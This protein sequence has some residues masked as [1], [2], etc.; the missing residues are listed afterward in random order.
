MKNNLII[1]FASMIALA[2]VFAC[3]SPD[4][5]G[6]PVY[7][8]VFSLVYIFCLSVIT[9]VLEL[10]YSKTPKASRR[11][12]AIVLAFSPTI[13]LAIATLSSLTIID[14]LLA[15]GI[16][17]VIVWYGLKGKFIK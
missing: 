7:L 4:G 12:T 14:F 6:L 8:A 13:L 5:V 15:L 9:L 17:I 2:V 10:A 16:P 11:F 1:L 3:T